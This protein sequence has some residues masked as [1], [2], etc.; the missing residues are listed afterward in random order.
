MKQWKKPGELFFQHEF[1]KSGKYRTMFTL[2]N[3]VSAL[4]LKKE[5]F[6]MRKIHGLSVDLKHKSGQVIQS[7]GKNKDRY[8][9]SDLIRFHMK[10]Q[11][12]DVERYIVERNGETFKETTL[13]VVPFS[14][15]EV[16][17]HFQVI[18]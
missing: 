8:P 11:K 10:V 16:R 5:S 9:V 6:V 14:T 4:T 7:Y 17:I 1:S 3:M 12:G 2:S 18:A 15:T 13:D